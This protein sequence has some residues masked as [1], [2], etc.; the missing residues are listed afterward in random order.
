MALPR[1]RSHNTGWL[2]L[3]RRSEQPYG[4]R[5][6]HG[7]RKNPFAHYVRN[8]ANCADQGSAGSPSESGTYSCC[9]T[10]A[11]SGSTWKASTPQIDA[12][13]GTS[14]TRAG[15]C[16]PDPGV[17]RNAQRQREFGA[18]HRFGR[19]R[20]EPP[21]RGR[22]HQRRRGAGWSPRLPP[23]GCRRLLA[24]RNVNRRSIPSP[25]AMECSRTADICAAMTATKR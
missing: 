13:L 22:C 9:S 24:G 4:S 17:A 18:Y 12:V 15:F 8:L 25:R 7:N 10:P 11:S 16:K 6:R 2:P 20:N 21:L 19:V 5:I 3:V 23:P 14:S 1:D